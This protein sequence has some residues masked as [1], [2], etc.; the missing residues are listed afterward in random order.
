[1]EKILITALFFIVSCNLKSDKINNKINYSIAANIKGI[2]DSTK[3][4]IYFRD[5]LNKP[6]D[7][8]FVVNNQFSFFGNIEEPYPVLLI[9]KADDSTLIDYPMFNFWLDNSK[10]KINADI[11]NYSGGTSFL[12]KDIKG[13]V[14]NNELLEINRETYKL[15]KQ[16]KSK[17][18]KNLIM[19]IAF[20]K[21]NDFLSLSHI[22]DFRNFISKDS[23]KIYYD[24]LSESYKKSRKGIFLKKFINV[25]KLKVGDLFRDIR[26]KDLEGNLIKL[27]D[28]KGKIVL[29][30]FWS[31]TC[32]PCRR[33][34]REEFPNLKRKYKNKEFLIVSFSLDTDYEKWKKASVEDAIDWINISDLKNQ[35][36]KVIISYGVQ[37]IPSTFI[38]DKK[39]IIRSIII[40][41]RERIIENELEKIFS[42]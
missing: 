38:I 33:Q 1:M 15:Y 40:G 32:P 41:Y 30:D 26:A 28:F 7:S 14:L 34:I 27:S 31:S 8:S 36:S 18:I 11:K 12:E 13:S 16:G 5:S 25:N 21:P 22:L 17:L 10:I 29:L 42:K 3:V 6:I 19:N 4:F 37:L 20:N 39:G 9:F 23:L 35:K 2:K 24:K